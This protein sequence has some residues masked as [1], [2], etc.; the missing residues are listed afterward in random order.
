MDSRKPSP[1]WAL[2][3]DEDPMQWR[4]PQAIIPI[5]S[6]SASASSIEWV[7]KTNERPCCP[8]VEAGEAGEAYPPAADCVYVPL[9]PPPV[10]VLA[11]VLLVLVVGPVGPV[12][13]AL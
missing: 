4:C 9:L 1:Y 10:L 5:R 13:P 2:S 11:V 3:R 12:V 7:V 8:P 6:Q